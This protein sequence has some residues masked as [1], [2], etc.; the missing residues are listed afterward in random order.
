[1]LTVED[2]HVDLPAK[3]GLLK[4][5]RG[6]SL[7][8]EAGRTLAIVGESGS[9]K[10][11]TALSIMG[12]LPRGARRRARSLRFEGTDLLT[13]SD[14]R[15]EDMRGRRIG[16]IFQDPTAAFN[17]SYTIGEQLEEVHLRHF[18]KGRKAARDCALGMLEQVRM[19]APVQKP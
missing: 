9:G 16:M 10:S 17:P 8:V 4:V 6:C 7:R 14:R 3:A 1:M 13:L 5:V 15:M 12:L 19:P 11:V 2:L 18:G